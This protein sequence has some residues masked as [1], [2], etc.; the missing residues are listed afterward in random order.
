[1][2]R[3]LA[4]GQVPQASILPPSIIRHDGKLCPIHRG[5]IAMSGPGGQNM[6]FEMWKTTTDH[7]PLF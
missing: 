4:S 6:D 5:F 1:M 3:A 2:L 7:W